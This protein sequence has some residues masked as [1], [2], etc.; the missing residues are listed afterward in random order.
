MASFI[1]HVQFRV[2]V[3]FF[4]LF[5]NNFFPCGACC[6]V[7]L[8]FPTPAFHGRLLLTDWQRL[9]KM[10]LRKKKSPVLAK[11][12]RYAAQYLRKNSAVAGQGKSHLTLC[13][14]LPNPLQITVCVPLAENLPDSP[15]PSACQAEM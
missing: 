14:P 9:S 8:E 13:L 10:H 5:F 11:R 15:P 2:G 7:Q 1:F 3:Y 4:L 6:G 12:P